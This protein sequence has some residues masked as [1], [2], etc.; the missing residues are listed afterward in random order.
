MKR[1]QHSYNTFPNLDT[2]IDAIIIFT[3][4]FGVPYFLGYHGCRLFFNGTHE[5]CQTFGA[6]VMFGIPVAIYLIDRIMYIF[7]INTDK[8]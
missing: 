2:F 4:I 7:G 8:H 1:R 3:I 5:D 6:F